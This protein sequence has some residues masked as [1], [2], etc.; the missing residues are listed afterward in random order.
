MPPIAAPLPA[1]LPPPAIAP[2]AAPIAAP[3][4]APIAE[5]FTTSTVLSRE[6]VSRAA[7]SLQAVT[8]AC[9]GAA[10]AAG[11][12]VARGRPAAL[13]AR[14]RDLP[15]APPG[16]RAV[17]FKPRLYINFKNILTIEKQFLTFMHLL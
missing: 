13:P 11:P 9:V 5:S 15:P 17:S 12:A 6:P 7:T 10:G 14:P 8:T 1:P 2:P 4:T 16:R 3:A